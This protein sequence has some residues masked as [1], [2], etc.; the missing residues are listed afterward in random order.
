LKNKSLKFVLD[1]IRFVIAFVW[2]VFGIL[3]YVILVCLVW[4]FS[5]EGARIVSVWWCKHLA[6][7]SGVKAVV[8]GLE[9]LDTDKHYIFLANH[10]SYYD[11][12]ALYVTLPF[13]LSFIAKKSL[14]AIPVWGWAL[15]LVGHISV[16]RANPQNARS[17]MDKAIEKINGE[18]RSIIAFPEGS[19]SR[20]NETAEFK[21][22]I[23]SLALK[24]GVDIA[25]IAIRGA[26][27]VMPKGSL[28]I[29]SGTIEVNVLDPVPVAG[30]TA[31]DKFALAQQTRSRILECLSIHECK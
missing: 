23:F 16:D 13:K 28:F 3:F 1:I 2:A 15:S 6:F 22:G 9:K 12:I 8:H 29:R 11:I 30:V 26:R 31:S 20:T 17:S 7:L 4:P 10:S 21:L 27:D 24:S 5:K 25:P 18:K 14:F 19:R